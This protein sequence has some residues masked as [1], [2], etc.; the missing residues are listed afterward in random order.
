MNYVEDI[1]YELTKDEDAVTQQVG[2]RQNLCYV[3]EF[4]LV[5]MRLRLGLLIKD[6]SDRFKTCRSTCSEVFTKWIFFLYINLKSVVTMP[7]RST[8]Q[9]LMDLKVTFPN[10]RLIIDST[11]L[12]T[13]TA[14]SLKRQSLTYS[15][16]KTGMTWKGLIGITP[17]DVLCF[18]SDLYCGSISDHQITKLSG[19]LD[20][21][22]PGD[23]IMADKGM[24]LNILSKVAFYGEN[25]NK[26]PAS[27]RSLS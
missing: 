10:C 21:L 25:V 16:Y 19:L 12:K 9:D 2:K 7:P 15:H 13:N 22:E 26:G 20:R 27:E 14:S 4:L 24:I 5:L 1:F 23:T 18:V 6:L 11:E 17:N 8:I 3:D